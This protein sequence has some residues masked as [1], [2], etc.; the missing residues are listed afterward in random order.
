M[1]VSIHAEAIL[2]DKLLIARQ[3]RNFKNGHEC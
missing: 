2:R 1:Q 3:I